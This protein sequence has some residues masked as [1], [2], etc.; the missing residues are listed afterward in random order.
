MRPPM[1]STFQLDFSIIVEMSD[2][3]TIIIDVYPWAAPTEAQKRMFDA[4]SPEEQRKMIDAA[5]EEGFESGLSNRSI[6]EIV[7]EAKAELSL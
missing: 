7:D 5:I 4:L 1:R 2:T 6:R 3:K